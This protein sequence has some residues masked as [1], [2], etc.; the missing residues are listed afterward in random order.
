M[1]TDTSTRL[2][3]VHFANF[4]AE[5]C[6]LEGDDK[7]R[8]KVIVEE[9]SLAMDNGHSCLELVDTDVTMVQLMT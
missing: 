2:L 4:L 7:A 1:N 5:R 6:K 3:D 8:F 9:L